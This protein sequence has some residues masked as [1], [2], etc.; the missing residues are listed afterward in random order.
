MTIETEM[1]DKRALIDALNEIGFSV[2]KVGT[3]DHYTVMGDV[4]VIVNNRNRKISL[5]YQ[6]NNPH[7]EMAVK[8]LTRTYAKHKVL[9]DAKRRGITAKWRE[10]PN[11]EIEIALN[12][13]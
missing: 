11:G 6:Q 2:R 9:N 3:R 10:L 12:R 4:V 13:R 5:R 1:K 7:A 8:R